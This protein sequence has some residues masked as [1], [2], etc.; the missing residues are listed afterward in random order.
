MTFKSLR[1]TLTAGALTLALSSSALMVPSAAAEE[2]QGSLPAQCKTLVTGG[3]FNWGV[4]RSFRQYI[5]GNIARGSWSL[6]GNVK[7]SDPGN[8]AGKDFQFKF[9]VDPKT[10]TIEVNDEGKVT[11][12]D[13]R[14][15]P[16]KITFEGHKGSLYTNFLN[17]YV[18]A[19]GDGIQGGAGYLAYYVPG[20]GMTEYTPKD[21]IEKNRVTG[22]DVFSKGQGTWTVGTGTIKLDASNMM[23]VPKPGTDSW[24]GILEGIDALFMGMYNADYKPELDDIN[25]ELTTK[26]ECSPPQTPADDPD[27]NMKPGGKDTQGAGN[28]N[29]GSSNS[30]MASGHWKK[31]A[32]VW[33]YL[34]GAA[35]ILGMFAILAHA[36]KVSGVFEGVSKQIND[37]LHKGK[38]R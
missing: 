3:T 18:I 24:K 13:I 38:F 10:S 16:S 33:N 21:R 19:E 30:E 7:E 17:P 26:K 29:Q 14:T 2:K 1:T 22:S 4:K 20:K 37:F 9:E 35:G 15:K 5:Q 11:K 28:H 36:L 23:Y 32:E 31:I 25:V 6:E 8:R 27:S 34:L 12:A